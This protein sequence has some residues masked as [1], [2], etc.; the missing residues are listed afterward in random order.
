MR[1]WGTG[2]GGGRLK[3]GP[4]FYLKVSHSLSVFTSTSSCPVRPGN[5]RMGVSGVVSIVRPLPGAPAAKGL[6]DL[7][8][9][10]NSHS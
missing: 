2:V 4:S 7:P 10:W 9:V 8:C 1:C 3:L 6:A 5:H